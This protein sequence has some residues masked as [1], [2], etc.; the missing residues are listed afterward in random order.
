MC[1]IVH[2]NIMVHVCEC[3]YLQVCLNAYIDLPLMKVSDRYIK[4]AC[5]CANNFA[6]NT[7]KLCIWLRH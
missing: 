5:E 2:R 1:V 6:C 4:H 3:V 7:E